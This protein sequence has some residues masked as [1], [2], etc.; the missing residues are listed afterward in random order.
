VRGT[1]T[2]CG[3]G[4]RPR[5]HGP[6]REE[7]ERAGALPPV[8]ARLPGSSG[9]RGRSA[10]GRPGGVESTGGRRW[11][12]FWCPSNDR[13]LWHGSQTA[14]V[15][16]SSHLQRFG[17]IYRISLHPFV[18]PNRIQPNVKPFTTRSARIVHPCRFCNIVTNAGLCLSR[19]PSNKGH[20]DYE[21]ETQPQCSQAL[22]KQ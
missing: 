10:G 18:L 5:G 7:L 19:Q 17:K 15:V 11:I 16:T 3:H 8:A 13:N 21:I 6:R 14:E 9:A 20:Q 2:G 4:V 12:G 1:P 22:H